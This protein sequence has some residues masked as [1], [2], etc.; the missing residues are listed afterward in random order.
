MLVVLMVCAN[1]R[2]PVRQS[3][4]YHRKTKTD[5]PKKRKRI[6]CDCKGVPQKKGGVKCAMHEKISQPPEFKEIGW[7]EI[8]YGGSNCKRR[9][10]RSVEDV[11][12][13][14]EDDDSVDYTYDPKPLPNVPI[15]WPTKSGKTEVQVTNYCN[16]AIKDSAPGKICAKIPDFNFTSFMLQCIDDIKVICSNYI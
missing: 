13:L 8:R 5:C 14:P 4:F 9:T 1:N 7:K 16:K 10:R 15:D 3:L 11:I 2:I 12:I 6:Y